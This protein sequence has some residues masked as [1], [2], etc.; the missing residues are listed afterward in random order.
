MNWS[1]MIVWFSKVGAR[2][3]YRK[4]GSVLIIIHE[5]KNRYMTEWC[6]HYRNLPAVATKMREK[7]ERG[8]GVATR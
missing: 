8:Q 1:E 4:D 5:V 2:T 6:D 7:W 3:D